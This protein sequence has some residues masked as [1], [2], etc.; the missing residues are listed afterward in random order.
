M[1]VGDGGLLLINGPAGIGKTA[2]IRAA[3]ARARLAGI[4]VLS[5]R[6]SQ[7]EAGFS[8]GV[9][10][11]LFEPLLAAAG[12]AERK[13]LLAG[14]A[15]RAESALD[16]HEDTTAA[17]VSHPEFAA[18]HGLYWL[19]VN[20]SRA[21]P[22]L[23]TI[24]DLHD[25]D[26]ASM[27]FL[28]YLAARLEGVPAGLVASWRSG[29]ED[30]SAG[31]LLRL[32]QLAG[33]RVVQ[34]KTLS[35]AGTTDVVAEA[36]GQPPGPRFAAMC[37]AATG[38]NPFLVH[39]LTA[40]LRADGIDPGDQAADRVT[41]MS[42]AS[43]AR[44][45]TLRLARLGEV[46]GLLARATAILGDGT[47]LRHAAAIAGV[48]VA[49]A[50]VAVDR[51]T[52]IGVLEAGT[53]LRF[54]HPIVRAAVHDGIPVAERGVLHAHAV[55]VLAAA[56]ADLEEICAHLLACEPGEMADAAESLRMAASRAMVRGA[57]QSAVAYLR[58]AVAESADDDLRALALRDLGRAEAMTLDPAAIPHL[59]T[60]LELT[61][62]E[63]QRSHIAVDLAQ[64]LIYAGQWDAGLSIVR[65]EVDR[66]QDRVSGH[67]EE[68][69]PAAVR[70]LTCWAVLAVNDPRMVGEFQERL[71]GLTSIARGPSARSRVLAGFLAG[72]HAHRGERGDETFELLSHAFEGDLLL[73]LVDSD[74]LAVGAALF[75]AEALEDTQRVD[76][77]AE[78][79]LA[80]SRSRGSVVGLVIGSCLRIAAR[81][82][83]G[84]LR[85]TEADLRVLLEM[86]LENGLPFAIPQALYWGADAL[87][88]RPELADLAGLLTAFEFDPDAPPTFTDALLRVVRG[89]IALAVDDLA[90]ATTELRAA[91]AHAK[92]LH[93]LSPDRMRWNPALALVAA[94][95][96]RTE[97]LEL[98]AAQLNDARLLGLP[99]HTGIALRTLGVIEGGEQGLGHLREAAETLCE[100]VQRLEYARTLVEL[101]AALRRANQRVAARV[102]LREA[103]DLADRCGA[104]R[105]AE[106]ARAE[107]LAAGARPRRTAL[108]GLEA[109]TT[110][111]RRV[112]ELAAGGQSNP[113]IAQALF[114]TL[115]TVEGHLRHV[116]KKLSIASRQQLPVA[117][118]SAAPQSS[119]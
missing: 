2:L 47:L 111:E 106:R 25:A 88:E 37:Q 24:D 119:D 60:A 65:A 89:R 44:S 12:P 107:L 58:R 6:C 56:S 77:A 53:P 78:Q 23:L 61:G 41:E 115:N 57:P 5:A 45:V 116:F 22:A 13:T 50:A 108:T 79:L 15:H 26:P 70:L 117:L 35:L 92:E 103:L 69:S 95:A 99:V 62:D 97:G 72:V 105:L 42:P 93:H 91:A 19:I 110:M 39:E 80:Q 10:R 20:A 38:G 49:D 14:A 98:A 33:P 67:G 113:E 112:A 82:R 81:T 48:P 86:A 96:D 18:I 74:R 66:R 17:V 85:G 84:D 1:R 4:R 114:V 76:S 16:A 40:S 52:A 83:R 87:V 32:E 21:A 71:P 54:V 59:R 28:L 11:Q 9:A 101:G 73:S 75:A 100:S 36:F 27:D 63:T 30:G 64:L 109:L 104:T 8:F 118:R 43:V 51:L 90:T 3:S 34:P 7:L 31:H 94:R 29:E 55:R 68:A 46:P 102:P